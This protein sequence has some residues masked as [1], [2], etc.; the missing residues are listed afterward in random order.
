[1]QTLVRATLSTVTF[2]IQENR[3]HAQMYSTTLW[4]GPLFGPRNQKSTTP[5]FDMT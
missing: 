3:S 2:G 4:S 5:V 1:M